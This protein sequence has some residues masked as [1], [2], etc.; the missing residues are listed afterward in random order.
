MD[1]MTEIELLKV[2]AQ[3][4]V[5]MLSILKEPKSTQKIEDLSNQIGVLEDLHEEYK[6]HSPMFMTS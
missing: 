2:I 3:E 6:K 4:S 5:T 1:D